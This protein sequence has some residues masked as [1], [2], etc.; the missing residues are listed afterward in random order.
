MPGWIAAGRKDYDWS[1]L[2]FGIG[3]VAVW[4]RACVWE[5]QDGE[6]GSLAAP[7]RLQLHC[8]GVT[9]MMLQPGWKKVSFRKL[10][11]S[12]AC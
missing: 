6:A 1:C 10:G 8:T 5:Q 11:A 9:G 12:N 2:A 3:D 7:A 4:L